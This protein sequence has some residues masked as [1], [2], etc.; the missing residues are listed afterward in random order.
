MLLTMER[1]LAAVHATSPA[2]R[3]ILVAVDWLLTGGGFYPEP[4]KATK[5]SY[6][7][8]DHPL[9]FTKVASILCGVC[10]LSLIHI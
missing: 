1:Q 4:N 7:S 3:G 6:V 9:V 5:W 8:L 10:V 2:A